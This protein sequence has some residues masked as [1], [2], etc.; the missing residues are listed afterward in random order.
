MLPLRERPASYN[1]M[2]MMMKRSIARRLLMAALIFTA[3][4]GTNDES[5]PA[6]VSWKLDAWLPREGDAS[7]RLAIPSLTQPYYNTVL[8]VHATVSA[9]DLELVFSTN[10]NWHL[11]LRRLLSESYF[12]AHPSVERSHLITTSPPISVAQ[13]QTGVVKV[14]NVMYVDAQPHLVVAPGPVLDTLEGAGLVSGDR[15][16][17]IRTYGNVILKRTGDERFQSFWDLQNVEPGRFASSDP[18]EGGSYDNYRASVYDIAVASPRQ[19][20]MSTAEIEA[21]AASLRDRLFDEAGVATLGPPMHRSVPHL[22]ATGKAD[23]GLFFLHLAV[24]AMQENPGVFS[25]VY[26]ASGGAMETDDPEVL[27]AGQQPLEGNRVG[28]F[29]LVR[30]KLALEPP[31][32]QAV[33]DFITALQSEAFTTILGEVGLRRPG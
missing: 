19:P 11:A 27:A 2:M 1:E 12:P 16:P 24:T 25:A 7:E 32:Q 17:I 3:C 20:G 29:A 13:L 30:T 14:G 9:A 21:E 10:G 31:Q 28:T 15:V 22:I 33:D 8:D 4:D 18:A 5:F 6:Q 23:A 26:L